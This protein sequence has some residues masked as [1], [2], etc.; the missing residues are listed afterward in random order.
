M[1]GLS[2]ISAGLFLKTPNFS[3]GLCPCNSWKN[4]IF[5]YY[6]NTPTSV[7]FVKMPECV[8][9]LAALSALNARE[10][11]QRVEY[12]VQRATFNHNSV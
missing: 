5:Y 10:N 4:N 2:Y 1:A 7:R 11:Q 12:L 8:V 9:I 3:R 6:L